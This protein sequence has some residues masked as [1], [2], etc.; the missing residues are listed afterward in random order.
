[1][2]ETHDTDK[3][4]QDGGV[5]TTEDTDHKKDVN[6]Q[7]YD[8]FKGIFNKRHVGPLNTF[9]SK[10]KEYINKWKGRPHPQVGRYCPDANSLQIDLQILCNYNQYPRK[11]FFVDISEVIIKD[12]SN[13]LKSKG[14]RLFKTS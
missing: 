2:Q 4:R 9:V 3:G 12:K 14:A 7:E 1:M 13:Y 11:I 8:I 6:G 10:T 5:H